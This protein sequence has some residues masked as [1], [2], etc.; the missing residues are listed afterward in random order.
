MSFAASDSSTKTQILANQVSNRSKEIRN[1]VASLMS[2][3]KITEA[4]KVALDLETA[5]KADE[6]Y[7]VSTSVEQEVFEAIGLRNDIERKEYNT[8]SS[9]TESDVV[10]K[11]ELAQ[12]EIKTFENNASTTDMILEAEK[13]LELADKYISDKDLE[14]AIISLQI[15]DRIVAEL[16]IILLP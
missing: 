7:K 5:L 11:I 9:S 13:T 2:E 14:N 1:Q 6:L 4:K 8:I 15:Y 12:K 3:N 10:K 16:K